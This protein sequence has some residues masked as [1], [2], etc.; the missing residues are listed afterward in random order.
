MVGATVE[1]AALIGSL[2]SGVAE[3]AAIAG[4]AVVL[5]NAVSAASDYVEAHP[6]SD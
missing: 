4:G 3:G 5:Y 1:G 2:A 6:C